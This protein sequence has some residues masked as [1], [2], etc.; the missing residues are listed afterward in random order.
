MGHPLINLG[1]ENSAAVQIVVIS[2]PTVYDSLIDCDI[3]ILYL[4]F[5]GFSLRVCVCM[6]ISEYYCS[7]SSVCILLG[8]V[9]DMYYA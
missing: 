9:T 5:V 2:L 7:F 6:A 8:V 1:A 3:H 4:A